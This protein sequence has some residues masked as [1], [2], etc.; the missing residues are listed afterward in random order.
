MHSKLKRSTITYCSSV[1]E[2]PMHKN[3]I[4]SLFAPRSE[5]A[6]ELSHSRVFAPRNIRSLELSFRGLFAPW[7]FRSQAFSLPEMKVLCNF[8]SIELVPWNFRSLN[9]YL[10]V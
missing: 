2:V 10:T 1:P 5:M 9:V 7:P 6:R 8:R 3:R 4:H